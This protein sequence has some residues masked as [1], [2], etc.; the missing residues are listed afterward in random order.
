MKIL[1]LGVFQHGSTDNWKLAALRR[2][3][4]RVWPF[5]YRDREWQE[6]HPLGEPW[7]LVVVSKGVPLPLE[8]FERLTVISKAQV[9]FWPD[10]FENWSGELTGTVRAVGWPVAATSS[11]VLAKIRDAVGSSFRGT[12]LLEGAD[13]EGPMPSLWT[14][15]IEP[16]LLHFGHLSER[17]KEV[18]ERLTAAGVTVHHLEKPLFGAALQRE[19]LKHAAV[20]GVNSSP[21]LYSNRVQTVLA[22]GGVMV[23]EESTDHEQ[24]EIFGKGQTWW[25]WPDVNGCVSA[26]RWAING[27]PRPS[28]AEVTAYWRDHSWDRWAERVL[29]FACPGVEVAHG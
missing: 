22:M 3:G 28:V 9:L 6:L 5:P 15:P 26:A 14:G 21:D 25:T 8:A 27:P 1:L 13:C 24:G 16:A 19:V 2:A 17:R 23:Q 29:E 12:R 7:D 20:L 10:P 4:H 11:V 18:I